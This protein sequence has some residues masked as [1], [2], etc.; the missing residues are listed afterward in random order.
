MTKILEDV[1]TS[2]A[3]QTCSK[4]WFRDLPY[5]ILDDIDISD[6]Q[7][8]IE[9]RGIPRTVRVAHVVLA[10][11]EPERSIVLWLLD[12][13]ILVT[14]HSQINRMAPRNMA[15]VLA[16]NLWE[17]SKHDAMQFMSLNQTFTD[18]LEQAICWRASQQRENNFISERVK[19]ITLD[20]LDEMSDDG[21][22]SSNDEVV[23]VKKRV[24]FGTNDIR[25]FD[26]ER[27]SEMHLLREEE[28]E[29]SPRA[30][31]LEKP[32]PIHE[33]SSSLGTFPETEG[34]DA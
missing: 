2:I 22:G 3:F 32:S 28:G 17:P 13:C 26:C 18:F 31:H 12:L 21:G 1:M 7:K 16:P 14:S 24:S 34:C 9:P 27:K 33:R 19:K 20:R 23:V 29:E 10:M 6:I 5:R 30:I 15:I 4:V 25:T 11:T 8:S